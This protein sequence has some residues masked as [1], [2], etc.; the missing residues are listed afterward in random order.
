MQITDQK[1]YLIGDVTLYNSRAGFIT[2]TLTGSLHLY[3]FF[4]Y[5]WKMEVFQHMNL[6]GERKCSIRFHDRAFGLENSRPMIVLF[7]TK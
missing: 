2:H 4:H 6:F 1:K 7:V 3:H 5:P